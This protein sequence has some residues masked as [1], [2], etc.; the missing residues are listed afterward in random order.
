[1]SKALVGMRMERYTFINASEKV[2]DSDHINQYRMKAGLDVIGVFSL[3]RED[4]VDYNIH[5]RNKNS[6]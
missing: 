6:S 4:S 2:D 5:H 3:N 1:M